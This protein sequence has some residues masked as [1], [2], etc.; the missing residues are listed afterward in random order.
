M[1]LL[2]LRARPRGRNPGRAPRCPPSRL[3]RPD[4]RHCGRQSHPIS[5]GLILLA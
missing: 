2:S 1:T 4:V 5:P 3:G